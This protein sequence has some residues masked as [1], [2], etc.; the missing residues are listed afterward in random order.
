MKTKYVP[1]KKNFHVTLESSGHA[2]H[3][4][5]DIPLYMLHVLVQLKKMRTKLLEMVC[6]Q[7][8]CQHN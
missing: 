2:I 4:V 3:K 5:F 8:Q 1:V 7:K 6:P